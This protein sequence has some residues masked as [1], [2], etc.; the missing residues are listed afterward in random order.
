MPLPLSMAFAVAVGV[1]PE[2]GIYTAIV[3]GFLTSFL[4]GSR[5]QIGGPTGAFV[6]VLYQ[7]VQREGYEGL[8]CA[9]LLSGVFLL[10]AAF[11]RLGSLFL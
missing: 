10:I 5:F 2:K 6:V 11:L 8:V 1:S 4:G 7:I 3:A 9:S